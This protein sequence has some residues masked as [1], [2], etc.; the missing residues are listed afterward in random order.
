MA[1]PSAEQGRPAS[2]H[3]EQIDS[4]QAAL[5]VGI[6]D[7]QAE[8]PAIRRLRAWAQTALALR[9]G[10]HA[11]D[12]GSGT[13]SE[14]IE[15]ADRVGSEGSAVGVD[16]N[17]AML[18]IAGE[19]A[20]AAGSAARFVEGSA[21]HL[22]FPDA[23]IDGVRCERV[24]QHLDDPAAATAEITRVLRP[25]GRV[26]LIDSDWYTAITHPGDPE[27][28]R[29]MHGWQ[30]SNSPN[31]ASGRTL[32]GLLTAAGCTVDDMASETLL[33]NPETAR[34]SFEHLGGAAVA[35]GAVTPEQFDRLLLDLDA[36]IARGDYHFSVTMFAVLAHKN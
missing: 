3:A 16:P 12:I 8:L 18:T 14:V 31:P 29:A 6:L 1:T 24:Y 11:L 17:P 20:A 10:D 26:V 15:F 33:W 28:V 13:G 22:P 9:P 34:P 19:R 4:A 7:M 2:F 5:L 21:Y 35:A 32:R 30:L 23:S 36:G 25:G 27:T